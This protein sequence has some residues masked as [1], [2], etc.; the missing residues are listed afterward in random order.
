[1]IRNGSSD[2]SDLGGLIWG[3]EDGIDLDD[4]IQGHVVIANGNGT[5]FGLNDRG[6]EIDDVYGGD[7]VISNAAGG[8]IQSLYDHAIDVSDVDQHWSD[9]RG[10][11]VYIDN[12]GNIFAGDTAIDL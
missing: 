10:G 4:D 2:D 6:I 12:A 3:E 7:V 5:I 8:L 9:D 1:I 11:G